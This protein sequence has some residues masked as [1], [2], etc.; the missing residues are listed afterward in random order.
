MDMTYN[1]LKEMTKGKELPLAGTTGDNEPCIVECGKN[2][3]GRFF[4]IL[5]AQDNDWLRIVTLW[6]DG[7]AEETFK[8]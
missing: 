5:I 4:K 2:E 8:K 6:E 1:E 7:T 3:N